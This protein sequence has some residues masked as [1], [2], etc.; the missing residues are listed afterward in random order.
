MH[1]VGGA[2]LNYGCTVA[3]ER[4]ER[5]ST[6]TG[7]AAWAALLLAWLLLVVALGVIGL[8]PG[9]PSLGYALFWFGAMTVA[10]GMATLITWAAVAVDPALL[11][12]CIFG[13][14][15]GGLIVLPSVVAFTVADAL[16][17]ERP[18][19]G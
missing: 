6:T 9:T 13:I 8:N 16:H 11:F 10:R 15:I 17:R 18:S 5:T 2:D 4:S 7:H 14:E 3:I 1:R 12:V 19:D